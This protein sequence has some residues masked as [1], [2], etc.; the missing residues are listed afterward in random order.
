MAAGVT[1]GTGRVHVV[2][3]G[4][5]NL[6]SAYKALE[7]VGARVRLVT[8]PTD[9][10]DADGVVLPGVGA[11][12]PTMDALRTTGFDR[13]VLDFIGRGRP[14]LGIC[15]GMQ[16]LHTSS[17]EAPGVAGLGV[18]DGTVRRLP[19]TVRVPQMQWNTLQV[20]AVDDPLFAGLGRTPWMYFVHSYAVE[21][22]PSTTATCDYGGRFSAAARTG[23]VWAAQFHPEK[24]GTAGLRMLQ[25]FVELVTAAN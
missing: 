1:G 2:D 17:D 8:D 5:G 4:I 16:V 13:A 9:L 21:V 6:R 23:N 19:S 20:E 22:G 25:N 3:H 10:Q 11:F 12:G 15:V 18:I 14:F 7:H 24:S